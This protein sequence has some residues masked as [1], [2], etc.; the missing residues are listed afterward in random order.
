VVATFRAD[1]LQTHGNLVEIK[2]WFDRLAGNESVS[3]LPVIVHGIHRP[4]SD[5]PAHDANLAPLWGEYQQAIADAVPCLEWLQVFCIDGGGLIGGDEFWRL[6]GLSSDAV[7]H[8]EHALQ[9]L[10]GM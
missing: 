6:R 5:A 4:S 8:S 9:G 1:V 3:C 10:E 2:N 7:S